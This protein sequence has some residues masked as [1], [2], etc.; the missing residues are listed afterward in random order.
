MF[1]HNGWPKTKCPLYRWSNGIHNLLLLHHRLFITILFFPKTYAYNGHIK[2]FN[3]HFCIQS[4]NREKIHE[5]IVRAQNLITMHYYTIDRNAV[6]MRNNP[7]IFGVDVSG[8][9]L[10]IFETDLNDITLL[11]F[12]VS[13]VDLYYRCKKFKSHLT[14]I[15][16]DSIDLENKRFTKTFCFC[17]ALKKDRH[18]FGPAT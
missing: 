7:E 17:R 3:Q 5:R 8:F 4:Y 10:G 18:L 2:I 6:D 1:I 14:Q 15:V 12:G 9:Y 13:P 16:Y 11:K